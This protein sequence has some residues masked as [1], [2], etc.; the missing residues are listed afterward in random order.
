MFKFYSMIAIVAS[1][2]SM[3]AAGG[4]LELCVKKDLQPYC[5]TLS[6]QDDVCYNL[7]TDLE[8]KV[9]SV[10]PVGSGHKCW[11]WE[12]QDCEGDSYDFT[13]HQNTLGSF[14][15]KASSFYCSEN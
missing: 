5:S 14:N 9:R 12:D 1:S 7:G 6:Y 11:L 10:D 8:D 3:V 15:D 13:K 2:I 4:Q